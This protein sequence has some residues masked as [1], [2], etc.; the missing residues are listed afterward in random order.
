ML[1][2]RDSA[3][4][5]FIITH[6]TAGA[7]YPT[8]NDDHTSGWMGTM[9]MMLINDGGGG[10]FNKPFPPKKKKKKTQ[11]GGLMKNEVQKIEMARHPME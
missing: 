8:T 1:G 3:R 10:G 9:T 2:G 11:H 5:T 4:A 6:A 7:A